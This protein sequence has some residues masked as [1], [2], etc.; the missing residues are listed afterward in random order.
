M[1]IFLSQIS[2]TTNAFMPGGIISAYVVKKVENGYIINVGGSEVFAQCLLDLEIGDFL[3]LKVAHALASRIVFK[4]VQYEAKDSKHQLSL[5]MSIDVPNTFEARAALNVLLK[6]NL[7]IKQE[8]LNFI[9]KLFCHLTDFKMSKPVSP[10]ANELSPRYFTEFTKSRFNKF[11][12]KLLQ[13]LQDSASLEDKAILDTS[14]KYLAL[15][16]LNILHN[17]NSVA[18]TFFF[19]LPIPTY[20]NIYLKVSQELT[21]DKTQTRIKLSFVINTK[22]LGAILVELDYMNG[23][24]RA[25]S[26]F[27]D[28]KAMNMVKEAFSEY[29]TGHNL[30]KNMDLKVRKVSLKDFFFGEVNEPPITTGIN[31][32]I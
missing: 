24:V 21:K 9:T 20:H 3:K 19:A 5:P 23:K 26:S 2:D 13:L 15:K 25:S 16:A 22:N 31:I 14:I 32:K 29:K 30:I 11:E 27:E 10:L 1:R 18:Q 8:Y 17:N 28:E 7:P 12:D 4:V 6:L